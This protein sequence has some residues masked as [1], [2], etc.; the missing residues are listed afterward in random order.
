MTKIGEKKLTQIQELDVVALLNDIP[1]EQLRRGQVGTVVDL[2]G[3]GFAL[4][5]F[6]SDNGAAI[7]IVAIEE[8]LLLPLVYETRAA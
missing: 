7:E 4:V 5:E 2:A 8:D 3:N 6:S 1:A